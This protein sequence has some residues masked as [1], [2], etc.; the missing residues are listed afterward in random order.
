VQP[1]LR[2]RRP[3]AS[4]R[5][6]RYPMTPALP[7]EV[8]NLPAPLI[9]SLLPWLARDCS[10]ELPHA[11][12]SP[13][14][15]VQRPLVLPRL[16]DAHDRVRQTALNTPELVPNPLEPAVASTLISGEPS[17]WDRAAPPCLCLP[18][19]V[20]SRASIRDQAV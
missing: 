16:C 9:W 3:V 19:A 4:L 14:C 20:R 17:P 13:P 1:E 5:H 6:R 8:S 18:L 15:H 2:H 11:T 12:V 10:P 7:L